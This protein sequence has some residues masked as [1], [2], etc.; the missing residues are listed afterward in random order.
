MDIAIILGIKQATAHSH[1]EQAKK[2]L[3]V[4]MRV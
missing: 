3:G 1:I 4:K 2:R